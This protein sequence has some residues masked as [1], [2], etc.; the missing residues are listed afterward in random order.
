MCCACVS[1]VE[2]LAI[3]EWCEAIAM[4]SAM[5]EVGQDIAMVTI[6][7]QHALTC[8]SVFT[9]ELCCLSSQL[10]PPCV[11][12]EKSTPNVCICMHSTSAVGRSTCDIQ[13][14]HL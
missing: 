14:H 10:V 6:S 1:F 5:L 8:G 9:F 11:P 2:I 3:S 4:C 13:P 12:G 7:P